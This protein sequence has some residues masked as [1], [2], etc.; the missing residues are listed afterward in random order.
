ME[1]KG[2]QTHEWERFPF[3]RLKERRLSAPSGLRVANGPCLQC[4]ESHVLLVRGLHGAGFLVGTPVEGAGLEYVSNC[5]SSAGRYRTG[6]NPSRVLSGSPE[7]EALPSS[8]EPPCPVGTI[9]WVPL[10]VARDH[11][12]WSRVMRSRASWRK[13][14]RACPSWRRPAG[15]PGSRRCRRVCSRVRRSP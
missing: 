7:G 11:S 9:A 1:W 10:L 3:H 4:A 8:G 2:N 5:A 14:Q 15:L 13:P 6:T 12:A